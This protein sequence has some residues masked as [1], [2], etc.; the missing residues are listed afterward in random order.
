MSERKIT[1]K[2]NDYQI[3]T[4]VAFTSAAF[5]HDCQILS[6]ADDQNRLLIWRVTNTKPK[7]ELT[8]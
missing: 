1:A 7:I 2:E 4:G 3:N 8:G 6:G 5:G